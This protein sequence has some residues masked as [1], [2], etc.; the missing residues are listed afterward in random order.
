MDWHMFVLI[1]EGEIRPGIGGG[2]GFCFEIDIQWFLL[3][4]NLD[5]KDKSIKKRRDQHQ[6]GCS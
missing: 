6:G 2:K 3:F 4:P 1:W 5:L